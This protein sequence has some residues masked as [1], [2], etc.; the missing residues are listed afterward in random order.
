[1]KIA[2]VFLLTIF[3]GYCFSQL[4]ASFSTGIAGFDMKDMKKHQLEIKAQFP[5]DVRIVESFPAYWFY[6][7]SLSGEI[8]NALRLGGAVG[9]TSTGGRLSYRD[10]SGEIEC[11]QS[12]TAWMAAVQSELLLNP[13]GKLP[14]SFAFET[15]AAFGRYNVDIAV[16][17]NNTR[18]SEAISFR[19]TNIFVE[20][21]MRAYKSIAG[22]LSA[23]LNAAYHFTLFKSRQSLAENSELFLLDDSGNQ[24]RL[25]WSGVRIGIGLSLSF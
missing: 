3:P 6:K 1:M 9:L 2:V 8:T 20:P 17:L 19:S 22:P 24:V 15:G 16:E 13:D 21:G 5:T 10:Y 25:D 18:E 12:T 4:H 14:I 11:D 23:S 7:G